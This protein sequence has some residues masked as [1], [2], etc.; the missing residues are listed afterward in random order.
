[1]DSLYLTKVC[2]NPLTIFLECPLFN[3]SLNYV[4]FSP[5]VS[6]GL[7][8]IALLNCSQKISPFKTLPSKVG[9]LILGPL[10]LDIFIISFSV[11]VG[12][13]TMVPMR[14]FTSTYRFSPVV[15][16]SFPFVRVCQIFHWLTCLISILWFS[17]PWVLNLFFLASQHVKIHLTPSMFNFLL[18]YI[19]WVDRSKE[20]IVSKMWCNQRMPM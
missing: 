12:Y 1:M 9:T 5:S 18:Y 6:W 4:N 11:C 3:A 10:I 7:L 13:S 19:V 17:S 14:C 16:G 2:V 8:R 15:P 20:S